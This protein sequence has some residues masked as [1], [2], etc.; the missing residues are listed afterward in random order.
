M[1]DRMFRLNFMNKLWYG[2]WAIAF[3]IFWL[4]QGTEV[5]SH[6]GL[7]LDYT[8]IFYWP[9]LEPNNWWF[10]EIQRHVCKTNTIFDNRVINW[11]VS[12]SESIFNNEFECGEF[13]FSKISTL[14]LVFHFFL[15]YN[16]NL[17]AWLEKVPTGNNMPIGNNIPRYGRRHLV[18]KS[19]TNKDASFRPTAQ[20][21][22]ANTVPGFFVWPQLR[23]PS[24]CWARGRVWYWVHQILYDTGQGLLVASGGNLHFWQCRVNSVARLGP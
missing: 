15:V 10:Y 24:L 21:P 19:Q 14:H 2:L 13:P 4:F 23:P 6:H 17:L 11:N 5:K 7:P 8:I 9:S 20:V 1:V 18:L 22:D 3:V 16:G 12:I